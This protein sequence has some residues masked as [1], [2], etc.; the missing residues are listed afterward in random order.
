MT[1]EQEKSIEIL[2]ETQDS[3][4]KDELDLAIEEVLNLIQQLQEEN[5]QKTSLYKHTMNE[6]R[7]VDEELAEKEIIIENAINE[8]ENLR[9]YFSEDLQPDFIS[10]L[11]ILK[12]KEK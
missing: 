6:L 8:V 3:Y 9:Q 5:K 7:R 4:L 11:E 10:I 2:K 12:N 1:K